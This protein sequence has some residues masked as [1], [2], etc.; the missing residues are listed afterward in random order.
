MRSVQQHTYWVRKQLDR[1]LDDVTTSSLFSGYGFYQNN[2]LFGIQQ[3]GIFYLRAEGD[4]ARLLEKQGAVPCIPSDN[5]AL[6]L[7][8]YYR[9]PCE[10]SNNDTLYREFLLRS[11]EQVKQQKID[12]QLAKKTRIKELPN[13]SIKHERLLIK[14]NIIN[15]AQLRRAGAEKAYTI[16]KKHGFSINLDFYWNL[17]AALQN[18]HVSLLPPEQKAKALEKL[19]HYLRKAGLRPEKVKQ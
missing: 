10:I 5:N 4:L 8:R 19:N 16:A 1:L 14:I 9:L 11:I 12:F 7:S 17:V 6:S 13:L 18:I 3:Y 2:H 15:V